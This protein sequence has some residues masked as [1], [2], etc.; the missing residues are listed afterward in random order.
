MHPRMLDIMCC[1]RCRAG[2]RVDSFEQQEGRIIHGILLCE[3][4]E[5]F[6]IIHAIPRLLLDD[7]RLPLAGIYPDFF[8]D[9]SSRLP[10][11]TSGCL[12]TS[13]AKRN[14]QASFG[15][16]W[17]RFSDYA[18]DNF[19]LFIKPLEAGFFCKKFGLDV[20][21]GAGRH[22]KQA[23]NLGAEMVGLDLSHS[24][25]S[26]LSLNRDNPASHFIQCDVFNLPIRP[27]V[28]DFIYSLGVLHHLP[29]PEQGFR[30]LLPTLKPS[31]PIFLWVYQRA[32]RKEWL[33]H[34]R[35]F[36]TRLPLKPV[37][38][39][40]W[41]ATLIDYGLCVNLY[42]LFQGSAVVERWT[43]PRIKEYAGYNFA[44]SYADW[45]D[46]LSAPVSHCY[47]SNEIRGWFSRAG[48]TNIETA[49]I[50]DSWVWGK[51]CRK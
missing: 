3:C 41:M 20:G 5:W 39:L 25:D 4:G 33:E 17:T 22:V 50:D 9:F 12:G 32:A 18:V 23:T 31:A 10:S 27:N 47:D 46:R 35:R 19:S 48:L 28:F 13:R 1:P 43:P 14:T 2:L 24:V 26:A 36:T 37:Q 7:L 40:A 15:Y 30:C 34:A 16:E 44:S 49:L 6:P 8:S 45:F 29:D 42:R 21:C 11:E 38:W 51:G